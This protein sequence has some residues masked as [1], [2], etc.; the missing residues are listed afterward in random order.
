MKIAVNMGTLLGFGSGLV[1]R[2]LL[3]AFAVCDAHTFEVW[4]PSAWGWSDKRFGHR[5]PLHICS[6][7]IINK[8]WIENFHLRRQLHQGKFDCLFS[9]GDTSLINSPVPHLLMVQQAYLSYKPTAWDFAMPP[10]FRAHMWIN[11]QYFRLNIPTVTRFSVQTK[12]MQQHLA[13]R[14]DILPERI[15]VIPSA[16]TVPLGLS[17]KTVSRSRR[18]SYIC[19]V[20]SPGVHKNHIVLADVM[21]ALQKQEIELTCKLTIS[22]DAVPE[23]ARRAEELGVARRIEYL[24]PVSPE[25]AFFMMRHAFAVIIPSKLESFGLSYYEALSV[26]TPVVA[27]QRDFAIEACGDAA[28]YANADSGAEFAAQLL[29]LHE[30]DSLWLE[31]AEAAHQRFSRYNY[32]WS[33]IAEKY[34]DLLEEI[35]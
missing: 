5:L 18:G 12:A 8:F 6:P 20:A 19:F 9:V 29:K 10:G 25:E 7:G 35:T 33:D 27:A 21:A 32:S 31:K 13:E 17:E 2:S 14:W 16:I 28:L 26:G 1:G 34:L 22:E 24:G 15:A 11:G 3:E 30:S 23:L 4:I